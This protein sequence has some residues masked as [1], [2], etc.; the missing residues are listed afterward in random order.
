MVGTQV[1]ITT[2]SGAIIRG[3]FVDLNSYSI[4]IRS[5]NL[6]STI[7]LETI[8][9]ISFGNTPVAISQ[10]VK[11]SSPPSAEMARDLEGV[12]KSVDTISS[13][14]RAGTDYTEYGR[15]LTDLRR[16]A[17]RF[18][19][20]F[21]D[22]ENPTE[23]RAVALLSGA[24]TDYTWART[25]WTL[26]L[27]RSSEGMV[28]ESDSPVIGDALALY[29]ELRN[30][31]ASGNKLSGDKLIGGLWKEASAKVDRVR[32]LLKTQ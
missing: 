17:E 1:V 10:P 12:L 9:G 5:D 27:G 6:E 32:A 14:T 31:A 22:S 7:A 21:S 24:L 11:Q 4:R 20:K 30:T 3:Q 16:Q 28:S 13:A 25:I 19:D 15:L 18:I 26:K 2:K 8:G 29:P 23:T